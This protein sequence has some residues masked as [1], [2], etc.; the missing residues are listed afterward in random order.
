MKLP[1]FDHEQITDWVCSDRFRF[2]REDVAKAWVDSDSGFQFFKLVYTDGAIAEKI[3]VF[4]GNYRVGYI[5]WT[6]G[7]EIHGLYVMPGYRSRG[8]A[9][10]LLSFVPPGLNVWVMDF[11]L[12]KSEE[13]GLPYHKLVDFYNTHYFTKENLA[14]EKATIACLS[15]SC[16]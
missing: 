1:N 16:S 12:M 3:V 9:K 15:N 10:K 6:D 11:I 4:D 7:Y 2:E 8:I 13:R 5:S 14:N